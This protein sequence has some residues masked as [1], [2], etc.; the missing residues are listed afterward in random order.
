MYFLL[1][2]LKH[3]NVRNYNVRGLDIKNVRFN[4]EFVIKEFCYEFT[5]YAAFSSG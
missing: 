3:E 1:V 4:C 2:T 5:P